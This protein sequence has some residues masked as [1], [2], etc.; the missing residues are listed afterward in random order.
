[1]PTYMTAMKSSTKI[2]FI[3]ISLEVVG[4]FFYI[5]R[6]GFFPAIKDNRGG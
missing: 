4:Y 2:S 5:T 6:E 1:V 3:A